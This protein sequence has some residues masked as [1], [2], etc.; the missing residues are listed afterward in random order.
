MATLYQRTF[1]YGLE[2]TGSLPLAVAQESA[3]PS[4]VWR[5]HNPDI[6]ILFPF[7]E[8]LFS[9]LFFSDCGLATI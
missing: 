1:I 7:L 3:T 9:L 2:S 5:F 4:F 8:R 6:V